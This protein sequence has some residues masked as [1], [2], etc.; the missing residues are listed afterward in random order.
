MPSKFKK[1]IREG[2]L[3]IHFI[4]DKLIKGQFSIVINV[5]F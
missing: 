2:M 4:H 3:I 5:P 1:S